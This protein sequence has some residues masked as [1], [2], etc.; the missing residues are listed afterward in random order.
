MWMWI[1]VEGWIEVVLQH[2]PCGRPPQPILAACGRTRGHG[3]GPELAHTKTPK[4]RRIQNCHGPSKLM[5]RVNAHEPAL[6]VSNGHAVSFPLE[7][8]GYEKSA[9]DKL[10]FV[11]CSRSCHLMMSR[12]QMPSPQAS[13]PGRGRWRR[14]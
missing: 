11:V 10:F 3:D 12:V 2:I 8:I 6:S 14:R 4:A 9:T 1:E 13:P 7:G 5:R